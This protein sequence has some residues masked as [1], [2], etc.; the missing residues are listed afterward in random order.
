MA[1][2]YS[3]ALS[4]LLD[5]HYIPST[6]LIDLRSRQWQ[7]VSSSNQG[8]GTGM[9]HLAILTEW[10]SDLNDA[11]VPQLPEVH[12]KPDKRL[13]NLSK[14]D[15]QDLIQWTDMLVFDYLTVNTDR[16]LNLLH[17]KQWNKWIME[18]PVHNTYKRKDSLLVLLDNESGFIMGQ[19]HL[20]DTGEARSLHHQLLTS[21]CVF[22]QQTVEIIWEL[23]QSQNVGKRLNTMLKQLDP[24]AK[25]LGSLARKYTDGLQSRIDQVYQYMKSCTQNEE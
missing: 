12:I 14:E 11:Y 19:K 17:N 4:R 20:D 6:I 2:A 24:L 10:V 3:F 25:K 21:T 7:H 15:V 1:D 5:M 16:M 9:F 18:H 22:R 13:A 23:S 8:N